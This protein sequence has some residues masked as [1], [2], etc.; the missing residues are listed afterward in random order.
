[1]GT[2]WTIR[3]VAFLAPLA[4]LAWALVVVVRRWRRPARGITGMARRGA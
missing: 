3:A 2:A 1:M 4:M